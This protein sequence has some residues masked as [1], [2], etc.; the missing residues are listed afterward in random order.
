MVQ[1]V[2]AQCPTSLIL[3]TFD[4]KEQPTKPLPPSPPT[5]FTIPLNLDLLMVL[6]MS[7]SCWQ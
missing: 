6:L 4:L 5:E 7:D 3:S 2:R 1:G